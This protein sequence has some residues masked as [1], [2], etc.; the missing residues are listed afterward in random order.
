MTKKFYKV[1][2]ANTNYAEA[3]RDDNQMNVKKCPFE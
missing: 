3:I 1:S 2:E